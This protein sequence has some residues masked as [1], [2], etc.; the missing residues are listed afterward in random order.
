MLGKPLPEHEEDMA[1]R[2]ILVRTWQP[3]IEDVTITA[4]DNV[5]A[6][7]RKAERLCIVKSQIELA[8]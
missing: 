1:V 5:C 6:D 7:Q 8:D 4:C 3:I 2:S